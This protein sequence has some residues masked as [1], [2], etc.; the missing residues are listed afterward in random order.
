M[1]CMHTAFI[2][3]EAIWHVRNQRQKAFL[4]FLDV[5]KAFNTLWYNGLLLKLGLPR[6]I[7]IIIHNW[8]RRCTSAA[9]EHTPRPRDRGMSEKTKYHDRSFS[10]QCR[11][12]CTQISSSRDDAV[13]VYVVD[14]QQL[15]VSGRGNVF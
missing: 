2:L 10:A 11:K 9:R 6:Y 1:S 5:K 4:A 15:K 12:V 8:Y 3:Q 14:V 7:W 13:V